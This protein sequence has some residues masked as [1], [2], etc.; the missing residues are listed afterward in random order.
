MGTFSGRSPPPRP[1]FLLG[2]SGV[3]ATGAAAGGGV[4]QGVVSRRVGWAALLLAAGLVGGALLRTATLHGWTSAWLDLA[5]YR[6]R[7]DLV[8]FGSHWRYHWL[9]TVWFGAAVGLA[10]ALTG[11]LGWSVRLAPH[12]AWTALAWGYVLVLTVVFGLSGDVFLDVR[13]AGHQARE[14]LTHGPVTLLLGIGVVVRAGRSGAR[15]GDGVHGW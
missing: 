3:A 12:R 13:H 14:I 10:P 11:R 1:L 6:T 2:T 15:D 7:D 5:Q 9:S 8:G 4:R